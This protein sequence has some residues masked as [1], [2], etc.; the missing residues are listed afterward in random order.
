MGAEFQLSNEEFLESVNRMTAENVLR[1]EGPA[2]KP[3]FIKL[4]NK[5]FFLFMIIFLFWNDLIMI[6]FLFWN[7]FSLLKY[8]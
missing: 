8:L 4:G 3:K 2:K 7:Y 6:I 5:W 1:K